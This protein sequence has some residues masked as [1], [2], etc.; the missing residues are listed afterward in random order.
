L[1]SLDEKQKTL[2]VD[3]FIK[4]MVHIIKT[5]NSVPGLEALIIIA[6]KAD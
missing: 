5:E 4:R 3:E 2:V 1:K 6:K